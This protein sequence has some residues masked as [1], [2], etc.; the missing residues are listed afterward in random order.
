MSTWETVEDVLDEVREQ[1]QTRGARSAQK[2]REAFQMADMD[3]SGDLGPLEFDECLNHVGVFLGT[4]QL[5]M[6]IRAVDKSGDKRVQYREFMEAFLVRGW[7]PAA[8]LGLTVRTAAALGR[9]A[10]VRG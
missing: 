7:S 8:G 3:G 10:S 5:S 6:L 9:E 2:L 1:L 4:P